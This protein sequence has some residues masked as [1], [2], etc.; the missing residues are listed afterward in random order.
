[1]YVCLLYSACADVIMYL[2]SSMPPSDN[3][4]TFSRLCTS[5]C[6]MA[7]HQLPTSS[8]ISRMTIRVGVGG[9]G[10]FLNCPPEVSPPFF[11]TPVKVLW[12]FVHVFTEG[13]CQGMLFRYNMG[14]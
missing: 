6:I 14:L 5:P 9:G 8:P 11:V 7:N 3:Y 12:E 2:L 13:Q 1:M 10:S 4:L